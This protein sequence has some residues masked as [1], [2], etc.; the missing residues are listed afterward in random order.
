MSLKK[1]ISLLVLRWSVEKKFTFILD[2]YSNFAILIFA[3]FKGLGHYFSD[4]CVHF[5]LTMSSNWPS[6]NLS[7]AK[8]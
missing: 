3:V 7:L 6:S 4:N 2:E 8:F 1:K 5:F